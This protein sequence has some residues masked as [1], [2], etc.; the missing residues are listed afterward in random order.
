MQVARRA[1][2]RRTLHYGA[3]RHRGHVHAHEGGAGAG[4]TCLGGPL[5]PPRDLNLD[6]KACALQGAVGV[7]RGRGSCSHCKM[8]P[9]FAGPAHFKFH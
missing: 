7:A 5:V 8:I 4:G 3:H 1:R 2:G 9:F 6:V